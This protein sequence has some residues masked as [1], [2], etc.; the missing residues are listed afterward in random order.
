MIEPVH[1][2]IA[3]WDKSSP[4]FTLS[5][6]K[7]TSAPT[8]LR[9]TEDEGPL[10]LCNHPSTLCIPEGR[11]LC[12]AW[13][14][15]TRYALCQFVFRSQ[16]PTGEVPD[17]QNCYMVQIDYI[18]ARLWE[19]VNGRIQWDHKFDYD[20]VHE[21]WVNFEITWWNYPPYDDKHPLAIQFRAYY[22]GSW[23]DYGRAERE[24][25]RW[26]DSAINRVG[27]KPFYDVNYLDDTEI[28]APV[29]P[30]PEAKL[31]YT[32]MVSDLWPSSPFGVWVEWD[33]SAII[34]ADATVVELNVAAIENNAAGCRPLGS[35]LFRTFAVGAPPLLLGYTL[36]VEVGA[37]RKIETMRFFNTDVSFR[38]I[39]YWT[40][41]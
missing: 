10:F 35:D 36:Q 21:K 15:L 38:L 20:L 40:P 19:L 32:S 25:A 24:I 2:S 37:E 26:H 34:P 23:H 7:W 30:P 13:C 9:S 18:G 6:A 14:H 29:W 39:G 16:C 17:F 3:D 8:S 27:F 31:I 22:S 12:Q 33:L 5:A 1:H 41:Q 4:D 28:H 11:L